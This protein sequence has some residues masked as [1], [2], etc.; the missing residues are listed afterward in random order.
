MLVHVNCNGTEKAIW[1]CSIQG[2]GPYSAL[3]DY[4]T[5]VVCQG[6]TCGQQALRG[7]MWEA[8]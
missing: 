8:K 5:S 7:V 1:D 2:W 3:L 4:D 6:E